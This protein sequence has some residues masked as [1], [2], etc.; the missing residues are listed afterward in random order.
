MKHDAR[1]TALQI[2][3]KIQGKRLPLD[4]AIE[5][6]QNT[7]NAMD[8]RDRRLM[9]AIVYGVL[10]WRSRLDRVIAESSRTSILKIEPGI[11]DILR[12]ALFQLIYLDRVPESA[13][14]NTAVELAKETSTS[15]G[16]AGFVNGVLR[17]AQKIWK[18]VYD[19]P[20]NL[21][22]VQKLSWKHAVPEWMMEG[23]VSRFGEERATLLAS[24]INRIPSMTLRANTLKTSPQKL[25]ETLQGKMGEISMNAWL[26]EAIDFSHPDG[27]IDKLPGFKDGLFQIQDAAAQLVTHFLSPRQGERI[28]DACAGYGGKTG[29]IAQYMKDKG[30]IFAVDLSSAKLK[31]L[32][33]EM[34]RLGVTSVQAKPLDLSR[35]DLALSMGRF[36]RILL[37]APCSGMGVIRRN[38]DIKWNR[39]P[40]SLKDFSE[41]QGL[42]L[43]NLAKALKPGGL[44]VYAVCS[45]EPEEGLDVI[46]SFLEKHPEMKR[47]KP[48]IDFP[49]RA[50]A[51]FTEKGDFMPWQESFELDGFYACALRKGGKR[52]LVGSSS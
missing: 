8:P 11:R 30:E 38:P 51:L 22:L 35:E 24:S 26:S 25:F 18:K 3:V 44:L 15:R 28:L 48:G 10:R 19:P 20:E 14:I 12:M 23:W 2:L 47:E 52:K 45:T 21:P 31:R 9:N 29:H 41:R 42:L 17:N 36:D 4:R 5:D 34:Q 43:E 39:R 16:A 49:E 6:F 50:R 33:H 27:A 7:I 40:E 1:K 32:E 13:A 37:D 46:E